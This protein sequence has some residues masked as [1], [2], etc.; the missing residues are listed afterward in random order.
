MDTILKAVGISKQFSRERE[1]SNIFYSVE[2]TDFTLKKGEFV[3]LRGSSG[4][5]KTTLLNILAGILKPTEGEVNF[6]NKNL[7]E[8]NDAE[9]ALVRNQNIGNIPQGQTA[10]HSLNVKENVLLPFDLYNRSKEEYIKKEK[11]AEELLQKLKIGD[12]QYIKP[13]E[14]SGGELRRVGL[15]RALILD[16]EL[17]IADEPTSDLDGRNT[18]I[19]LNIL[20]ERSEMGRALVVATH[21]EELMSFADTIYEMKDGRL[22]PL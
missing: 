11:Y 2:K 22:N 7:Y 16:P 19:V 21:D 3:V 10:I 5:G 4:S 1:G 18:E 12:L 15:A 8:L 14:L 13:S 17:I 6:L 20:K 9:L